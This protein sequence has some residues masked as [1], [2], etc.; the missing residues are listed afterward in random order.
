MASPGK[1][2]EPVTLE[3]LQNFSAPT[4]SRNPRLHAVFNTMELAEE[5]GLGLCSM[6]DRA[7]EVGLPLP[8]YAWNDP[9][10]DLTI[11]RT[12]ESAAKSLGP[13]LLS[14]LSETEREG[15]AFVASRG[16]TTQREYSAH[17]GIAPR[18]AQRHLTDFVK[19]G[20]L[21]RLGSG[22]ATEYQVIHP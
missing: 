21:R 13:Q 18:T 4:F 15:W 22:P 1:P 11:H 9:Y 20:L 7:Q 19:L 5:R 16:T 8:T 17:L 12:A 14:Q 2:I 10:L 6:R 3:Q